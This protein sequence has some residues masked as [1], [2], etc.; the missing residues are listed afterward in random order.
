[1]SCKEK[2]ELSLEDAELLLGKKLE[3]KFNSTKRPRKGYLI[4]IYNSG[5]PFI[6]LEIGNQVFEDRK[7]S[8]VESYK[9]I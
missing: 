6:V 3:V 5:Q 8:N 2:K 7:L 9:V 1:M 4:D